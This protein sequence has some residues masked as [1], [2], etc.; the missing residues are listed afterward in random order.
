M[1]A[2]QCVECSQLAY[3]TLATKDGFLEWYWQ[4]TEVR[5]M[6]KNILAK[7]FL[8]MQLIRNSCSGPTPRQPAEGRGAR[9][10]VYCANL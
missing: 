5:D 1:G 3:A 10:A 4:G 8:R 9:A 2:D 6:L 7:Q